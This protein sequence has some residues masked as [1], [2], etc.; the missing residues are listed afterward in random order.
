MVATLGLYP[1]SVAIAGVLTS[2]LGP[3]ILFPI[4]GAMMLAAALFGWL[5]REVRKL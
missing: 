2:R 5:Q 3:A 1:L 4:S